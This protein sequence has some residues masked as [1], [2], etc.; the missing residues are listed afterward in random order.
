M[1]MRLKVYFSINFLI[2]LDIL[3]NFSIENL[4]KKTEKSKEGINIGIRKF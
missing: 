2:F 3:E 1:I 4:Q